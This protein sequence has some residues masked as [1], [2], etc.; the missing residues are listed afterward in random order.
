MEERKFSLIFLAAAALVLLLVYRDSFQNSFHYDD[1]HSIVEN[2][3][4]RSLVNIPDFFRQPEMFSGI[5]ERAMYRPLLLTTY[6]LNFW[7]GE[8]GVWGYHLVNLI[9]HLGCV[10]LVFLLGREMHGER[11][12]AGLGALLFA[13]HPLQ[14]EVVNYISSRSES[15][16]ALFYLS[17]LLAY[18]RWRKGYRSNGWF[19]GSLGLFACGLLSKS[20]V[21]TL[22]VALLLCELWN[23]G[24]EE[25][26]EKGLW[27]WHLAYWMVAAGYLLIARGWLQTSLGRL[28][29]PVG[30]Q[31]LTQIKA[32]AY[33]AQLIAVPVHLNVEHQFSVA[34]SLSSFQVFLPFL[35]LAS[36][37]FLL[38]CRRRMVGLLVG[39]AV[40]PLLPSSL[41]PLNVLVN[42]HRL[43]LPLAFLGVAGGYGLA[44]LVGHR[45]KRWAIAGLLVTACL[46]VYQ[47]G[48]VW[49]DELSLWEDA[50]RK[51]PLMYRTHMHLGGALERQGR[52]QEALSRYRR[53]V[54][55]G[56]EVVEAHY[57]LGNALRVL[58]S[59]EEAMAAYERSLELDSGFAPSLINLSSM[60]LE[61][62]N[63][64]RTE[65]LLL[66]AEEMRPEMPEVHR[67]LGI[68]RRRQGDRAGAER[69][70]LRALAL[71]PGWAEACYSLANL[72]SDL[73]RLGE[74]IDF[75]QRAIA[76]RPDYAQA[77]RNLVDLY[78]KQ[79]YLA[80]AI[81]AAAQG[82]R[83]VPG[84][85]IL[86]YGLARAQEGLGQWQTAAVNYRRYLQYARVSS[87][88]EAAIRR[89]IRELEGG[90]SDGDEAR[91]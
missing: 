58:E 67:Q 70:L 72:Y 88:A 68:L 2:P 53:A 13:L 26:R 4:I 47:R 42:E 6:A 54:E 18:L 69:A 45:Q 49:K 83:Q 22:P 20:T 44:R 29:R 21:A 48:A 64:E 90:R 28:V 41:V 77:Y 52:A 43:Y 14:T 36:C 80:R 25:K 60:Q 10:L 82:L 65:D 19:W 61:R 59:A 40:L 75:Y 76:A 1:F 35:L 37:L 11:L 16:A 85:V 63:L 84:E 57:N 55:L 71:R 73:G 27:L 33:Y 9:I 56:P 34:R 5:P 89:R 32:I 87:E 81:E 38:V 79:G 17:G 86:Y 8:Y 24:K 78:T 51:A 3:H 23:A 12:A 74:S 46:L 91:Q 39:W 31:V 30:D 62:G 50:V 66:R 7:F 15:L